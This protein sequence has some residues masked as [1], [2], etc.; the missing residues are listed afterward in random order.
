MAKKDRTTRAVDI[1]HRRYIKEDAERKS[2][3]Q[4]ERVNAEVAQLIH[5]LRKDAGLTQQELA[6]LIGTTQSVLSRLEDA[7]YEGHSLSMLHR[8]A[9][10]LKQKLTV[11][12]TARDPD[13]KHPPVDVEPLL[14]KR[15]ELL[16]WFRTNVPSLAGAY[17]G[18]IRLLGDESFP[19]RIH[20]IAHAVRDITDRLVFALDS[21]LTSKQVQYANKLDDLVEP[22]S[23]VKGI[24]STNDASVT[25]DSVTID[26]TLASIIDSLVSDH[27]ARRQAPSNYELL[28]RYLMRSEP[29]RAN[30]NQRLVAEFKEMHDWFMRLA[31]LRAKRPPDI[32]EE[33]LN[34]QFN[35]FE[36][37]IH[38]F[39]GDFF[40]G[41]AELDD[42]LQQANLAPYSKP[43]SE[44]VEATMLLLG[45]PQHEEY[46]F[47][48]LDNP[49]WVSALA[50]RDVFKYPPR[51]EHVEG[52]GLRFPTWP[53]SRYLVRMAPLAPNEVTAMLADITT[54]NAS[55][56][57]D[58]LD[59][60]LAIPAGV[61]T[62]LVPTICKAARD[63]SLWIEFTDA[64][65]LCVRMAE[66]GE[67]A[68]AMT[69]AKALFTPVFDEGREEPSRYDRYSYTDGLTK[70]VPVL[71][72]SVAKDFLPLLC[73]WLSD[74]VKAKK[75]VDDDSRSDYSTIWRPAVEEHGQN[76]DSDFAST[77][78]G[79]VRQGFELAIRGKRLSLEEALRLVSDYRY[80]IFKRIRLHLIGEFADLAP[81]L[82][83][84]A[85]L[86]HSLFDNYEYKHEYATLVG[87]RLDLLSA[88]QRE[89]WFG[90]VDAGPDLS[91]SDEFDRK[92]LGREP[93][94]EERQTR[95]DWWTFE[96]LYCVRNYLE[97][98]RA[99][100]FK[101]MLATHGR[102]D[103]ADLNVYSTGVSWGH[104]SPMTLE[105]L[106]RMTFAEAVDK[107]S[108]WQP[109]QVGF[110]EPDIEGLASTFGEYVA[111]N[112]EGFSAD[113]GLLV[114]R[115]AIF[116][117]TFVS[118][119]SEAAKAG[120][121]L[122][123]PAVLDLCEWVVERPVGERITPE[124][125]DTRRLDKDW[126][127]TRGEISR[128]VDN[129][130]TARIGDAP[131]YPLAD[132]RQAIWGLIQRLS[133]DSAKSI[134]LRD[135]SGDDP[136][137]HDYLHASI[138][139]PRGD[140]IEAALEYAR[141]VASHKMKLEGG[142]EIVPG[143]FEAMPEVRELLEWQIASDNRSVAA[144]AV[145]GSRI[146]V[147]HWIDPAWLAEHACQLF[148]L[149]GIEK[150][151][152]I[153]QGWA[154]W[155]AFLVWVRPHIE[156]FRAFK[157]QYAYAVE[158]A[159]GVELPERTHGQPMHHLGRHL[160]IL[161]ARGQLGLNDNEGLLR[162]FIEKST[163]DVRR[164][165]ISFVGRLLEGGDTPPAAVVE[166]FMSLW[167][168]YWSGPG[169][170]DAEGFSDERLFDAWFSSGQL[171]PQWAIDRLAEFVMV[172][173]AP[174]RL[175]DIAKQLAEVAHVDILKSLQILDR[176]VRADQDGWRVYRYRDPAKAI[177]K[178]AMNAGGDARKHAEDLID[179]FGRRGYTDFGELLR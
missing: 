157:S 34:T 25:H 82:A 94:E 128:F 26:Q 161:F 91:D 140:A 97:G 100:F 145:I 146:G 20:F 7:D 164:S 170:K 59:A 48:R 139:S 131:R 56:I 12:M 119:M 176:V 137:V 4:T 63:G 153:S 123:L 156:F 14:P 104:A 163:P 1:L 6:D 46:F 30:V 155:N 83:R 68:S 62:S 78:V 60:A 134:F 124:H 90:W 142:R 73:D 96:K 108:T 130:C 11:V 129:V 152:P 179:Y 133:R 85:M 171:P 5:D 18:A 109:P 101:R 37:M 3:L 16:N 148:E 44:R 87:R 55:V 135:A 115:P 28:F 88:E 33:E 165:A 23:K 22:W 81:E 111:T 105:E 86:D 57:G 121:E 35:R 177:L 54:D 93:T 72:N 174:E 2:S 10:A 151:P 36:G 95:I 49:L 160:M 67:L 92:N 175:Y 76:H 150:T 29:T 106:S 147:I 118:Q 43:T 127:R 107:V 70:V 21:Q 41:T 125:G 80:L 42:I 89:E 113:A 116:V 19:G 84:K 112:P 138:N 40:T 159:A 8:V 50:D 122:N 162:R 132:V 120:R 136:R 51:A 172:A 144:M 74:S 110:K 149:E 178:L 103:L 71:A 114:D 38:S 58:I 99:E 154:A 79:F 117:R 32:P 47:S 69:L 166:R 66:G 75:L 27:C 17:E 143:A 158:Q 141:W 9:E 31:H 168:L 102:P 61:A 15:R 39:V 64:S 52:G 53:E 13:I 24:A 126:Q 77:M 98:E 167:E 45:S 173:A 169:K 65:D